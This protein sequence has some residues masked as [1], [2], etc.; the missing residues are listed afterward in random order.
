[1]TTF[2]EILNAAQLLPIADRVRLIDSLCESVP[3]QEWPLPSE[4]WILESQRR[5]AE[6]DAGQMTGSPWSEVRERVRKK[7]GL[8]A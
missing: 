7:V 3:A 5:S 6:Y 1:M 2:S 4:A 8:D